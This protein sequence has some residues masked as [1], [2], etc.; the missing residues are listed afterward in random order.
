MFDAQSFSV[1]GEKVFLHSMFGE[2][3]TYSQASDHIDD[4]AAT[5]GDCKGKVCA[6]F[7]HNDVGSILTYLAMMRMGCIPMP[8]PP[9]L[10]PASV[11]NFLCTYDCELVAGRDEAVAALAGP[12]KTKIGEVLVKSF[13]L[14]AASERV[15]GDCA[16]ILAT[17]GST[18]DMKAVRLSHQNIKAVSSAIIEY[19]QISSQDVMTTSLPLFY[20]YGLSVLHA[21]VYCHAT[22]S[23]EQ[24]TL[25]DKEYWR[26]L[27][28]AKV[29]VFS[30]V[31]AM[32][33][34]ISKLGFEQLMP[35]TLRTLTVAGGR[36]SNLRTEEYLDLSDRL[37]FSFF[38]MYGATEASPRMSYVPPIYAR[39]KIGSAGIPIPG[40][41]FSID[42]DQAD[43]DGEVIYRGRN[44]ALGYA[45]CR[46]DL[47]KKDEF[48]GSLRTGDIGYLDSD[49]FLYIT[50]RA[51]RIT[52]QQGVRLNLDHIESIL[53]DHSIEGMVVEVRGQLIVVT[54][55]QDASMVKKTLRN[56]ISPTIKLRILSIETLP[57]NSNGKR[58]H[59]TLVGML[60]AGAL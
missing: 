1:A 44:V 50:G 23:V 18:G 37:G 26:Q 20:S 6:L 45:A 54:T 42:A 27:E 52:K 49:G 3:V 48:K 5:L 55:K 39:K 58:D 24:F 12:V 35:T 21:A 41:S 57:H 46:S 19:L 30:A 60:E 4:I 59:K 28:L 9:D 56:M 22:L 13:E 33:D 38:S 43:Y 25:L 36:L 10:S 51:K 17:S 34:N 53:S 14:S 16:L 11:A 40:G 7:F 29:T 2:S 8:L 15:T 31:P 32:L 47:D